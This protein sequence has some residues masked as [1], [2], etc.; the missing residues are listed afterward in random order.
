MCNII[1]KDQHVNYREIEAP[2]SIFDFPNT[3]RCEKDLFQIDSTQKIHVNYRTAKSVYNI[4][5]DDE[6]WIYLY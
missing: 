6:T 2:L 4:V 1:Q 5:K 3:F